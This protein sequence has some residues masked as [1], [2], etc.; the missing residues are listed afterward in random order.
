MQGEL[1]RAETAPEQRTPA[2]CWPPRYVS[3]NSSRGRPRAMPRVARSRRR[4]WIFRASLKSCAPVLIWR[5]SDYRRR[6][7]GRSSRSS[8]SARL[9]KDLDSAARRAELGETRHREEIQ[10]LQVQLGDGRH[11]SGVVE[12]NLEALRDSNI[13]HVTELSALRLQL[14]KAMANQSET[15]KRPQSERCASLAASHLKSRRGSDRHPNFNPCPAALNRCR[16]TAR[17]C[18]TGFT[19]DQNKDGPP[20]TFGRLRKTSSEYNRQPPHSDLGNHV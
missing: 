8:A 15:R 2:R 10:A 5:K 13:S 11:R 19:E 1:G 9:H 16:R 6:R 3:R 7:S 12:G 17:R 4:G 18:A 20:A 14:A